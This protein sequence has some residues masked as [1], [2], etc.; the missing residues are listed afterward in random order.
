MLKTSKKEQPRLV[1]GDLRRACCFL[2]L[3]TLSAFGAESYAAESD[4]EVAIPKAKI[5]PFLQRYCVRC[6]RSENANGQV[7]FD[8]ATWVISTG[9]EAQRWQDVLD[10][11]NTG[12]MP[13]ED[14]KQ[15]FTD[16]LSQVLDAMTGALITARQRLTDHGGEIVMR[17]L[18]RREYANTIRELFG[19]TIP[20]DVIPEDREA[21]TFDT[22]GDEQF[23]N[24]SDFEKY[25]A[26]GREIADQAI[27]WAAK[28]RIQS[29]VMRIE[30]ETRV[31]NA[32]RVKLADLDNKMRMKKE[33]KTWQQMG[34]K[35][36]GEMEIVFRQFKSRAGK[37]REYLTYPLVDSGIYFVDVN[38]STKRFVTNRGSADPRGFYQLRLRAG[39]VGETPSIRTFLRVTDQ[40]G[41]VGIIKVRGTADRPQTIEMNYQPKMGQRNV[42]L[43]VEENRADIRVLDGYLKRIDQNGQW[44]AIWMDW[45]EI[46]GPFYKGDRA[47][48]ETLLYPEPPP[49]RGRAKSVWSDQ[50]VRDLIE[51]FAHEAFRRQTPPA[52]Y[53]DRLVALFQANRTGGQP[54]DNALS[55]VIGVILASPQFLFIQEPAPTKNSTKRPL[56]DDELAIRLSYFLWSGPPDAELYECGKAGSLSR[57]QVLHG[58]V[59]RMLN[60][61]RSAAFF[62]GF[63]SQWADLERFDA[64]TVDE[65]ANFRFNKGVRHSAKREVIEFFTTLVDENLSVGNLIQSEFV[66]INELLG[67]HYEIPGAK[68][69]QFEKVSLPGNS[70]RGG[71]LGQTAILT[72]GSN[73]ERSSPVI[74]G[75]WVMEKL[76]HDKPAP[77]PP[78][79]PELG[80]N[81]KKPASNRQLVELHQKQAVCASCHKK[82]D[83]IGFGL[84]NFDTTGRW[85]ETEQVDRKEVTIQSGGQLPGGVVFKDVREL[86]AAL[87][88]EQP[89]LAEELV[90]SLLAYGL[91]RSVEFSDVDEVEQI[92]QRLKDDDYPMRSMIHEIT[93]SHLFHTK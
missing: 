69:D 40:V 16:E 51:R 83:V 45:V 34:F 76:L 33:G 85:R 38:N 42:N 65:Q 22:V 3:L 72:L 58:Q 49:Q 23:F 29:S 60:D 84:E 41:T 55:E 48:V 36:E 77:P 43:G 7:R 32:L 86:K 56:T 87:L 2:I 44:A 50:N 89:Q 71:L 64:V 17:R 73:G 26:L 68:S 78:N 70:P 47:F 8:T 28:P 37:P 91:G 6:H 82:M 80:S 79:V 4:V 57:P 19:L 27:T 67:D 35:D 10:T 59:E 24:S 31:T 21:A 1:L 53:V 66:V 5:Q 30:P 20:E 62:E 88:L 81:T 74:R 92:L 39:I 61:P 15:P 12:D 14:E 63:V 93:N 75:A 11:L 46:E 9:D 18:N 25:L 13:P 54:F 52:D 90:E